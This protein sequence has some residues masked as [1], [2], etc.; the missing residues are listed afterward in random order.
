M[1]QEEASFLTGVTCWHIIVLLIFNRTM[2]ENGMDLKFR[3][4]IIALALILSGAAI[5]WMLDADTEDSHVIDSRQEEQESIVHLY[6][7]D[8]QAAFLVPEARPIFQGPDAE[9]KGRAI[10]EALIRGPEGPLLETLPAGTRL[11]NFSLQGAV[12]FV[13]LNEAVQRNHPGGSASELLTVYSLVN[14]LVENIEGIE[15]VKIL[16]DGK[17]VNTLAGHMDL[18]EAIPMNRQTIR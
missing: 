4:T 14:S 11:R 2:G 10:V 9:S 12:A 18:G 3:I 15:S 5:Y 13:D 17:Q 8:Q 1:G 6:F 7:G 16:I